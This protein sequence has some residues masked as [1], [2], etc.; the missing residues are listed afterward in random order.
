AKGADANISEA[1]GTSELPNDFK[2]KRPRFEK[3]PRSAETTAIAAMSALS[4][5][6]T[7]ALQQRMSAL[8]PIATP[9]ADSRERSCLLYPPKADMCVATVHVSFGPIADS[10]TA[11]K[12]IF[13]R[14][15]RWRG[16]VVK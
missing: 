3:Q 14:S 1:V 15:P 6:Q 2:D 8:P 5:K 13:I 16:R 11:A 10:C 7:H 4:Q 9:K 12:C